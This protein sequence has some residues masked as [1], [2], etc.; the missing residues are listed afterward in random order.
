MEKDISSLQHRIE[1]LEDEKLRLKRENKK[2]RD[3]LEDI[4]ESREERP[5]LSNTTNLY[6]MPS[7]EE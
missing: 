4:K 6:G 7:E 5:D 2:L 3:K 1:N